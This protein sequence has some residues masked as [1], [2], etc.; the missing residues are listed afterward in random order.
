MTQKTSIF[1]IGRLFATELQKPVAFQLVWLNK[2]ALQSP[3]K[4]FKTIIKIQ[5]ISTYGIFHIYIYFQ[6]TV[7]IN[8]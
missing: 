3:L 2:Q 4:I 7:E 5:N 1:L 6:N 8:L